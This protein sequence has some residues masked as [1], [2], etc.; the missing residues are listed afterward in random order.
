VNREI[1]RHDQV[2]VLRQTMSRMTIGF[3]IRPSL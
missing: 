3:G 2:A 1:G